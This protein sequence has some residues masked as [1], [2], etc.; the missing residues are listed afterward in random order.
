MKPYGDRDIQH[1]KDWATVYYYG[2]YKT[3]ILWEKPLYSV[4]TRVNYSTACLWLEWRNKQVNDGRKGFVQLPNKP[5]WL[6]MVRSF[7]RMQE[8]KMKVLEYLKERKKRI[9]PKNNQL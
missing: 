4:V 3:V 5:N 7:R 9:Q 1:I 8:K 6:V 2:L